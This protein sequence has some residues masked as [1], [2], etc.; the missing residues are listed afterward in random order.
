M[1]SLADFANEADLIATISKKNLLNQQNL[2]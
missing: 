1:F 2:R